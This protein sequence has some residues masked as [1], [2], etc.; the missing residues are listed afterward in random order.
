MALLLHKG[1]DALDVAFRGQ[2]SKRLTAFLDSKKSEAQET[3]IPVLATYNGL[4]FH[5]APSGG[6]GGYAFICNTGKTGAIWKL[7]RPSPSGDWGLFVSVSAIRIALHGLA[8]V[9]DY[10]VDTLKKFDV[11]YLEGSERINR[12][13]FAF[14]FLMP[15]FVLTEDRFVMG[16]RFGRCKAGIIGEPYRADGKSNRV[17][18]V[19]VGKNPGRQVVIY[20]KRLQIMTV[21]DKM[22]WLEIWNE[23][24]ERAG[25]PPIDITVPEDSRVWRIELRLY[26]NILKG[27][28]YKVTSFGTLER[29]LELMFNQV[30]ADVR[31]V[32]PT[33]DSNRSR[34]PNHPIWDRVQTELKSELAA[35]HSNLP[36]GRVVEIQRDEKTQMLDRQISGCIIAL[37]GLHEV[38]PKQFVDYARQTMGQILARYEKD[39]ADTKRKLKLALSRYACERIEK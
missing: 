32:L 11:V 25:L 36:M 23:N 20:D 30:L 16:Q 35:Q 17:T 26:K 12:V 18:G 24:L 3:G 38:K 10:L 14:D 28:T 13:D 6:S 4:K 27:D 33:N 2:I 29:K 8:K 21:R 34:W 7:K 22:F 5:V 15:D 9:R 39:P 37:A 31:Y 19:T 1:F